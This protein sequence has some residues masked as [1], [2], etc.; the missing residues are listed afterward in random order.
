MRATQEELRNRELAVVEEHRVIYGTVSTEV[1]YGLIT[2]DRLERWAAEVAI[3]V[4]PD[5]LKKWAGMMSAIHG[6]EV[7]MH[8]GTRAGLPG[9]K[10]D[11]IT[12]LLLVMYGEAEYFWPE[13]LGDEDLKRAYAWLNGKK[14]PGVITYIPKGG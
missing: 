11:W 10:V 5:A 13:E 14:V 1:A 3:T 2:A 9:Y 7:L 12:A 8:H 6:P 4:V